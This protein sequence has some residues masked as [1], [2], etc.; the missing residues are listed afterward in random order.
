MLAKFRPNEVAEYNK[1]IPFSRVLSD[2]YPCLPYRA[3]QNQ[4]RF[5]LHIGQRKLL[6]GDIEFITQHYDK[7]KV[8]VCAGAAQGFHYKSL[9][10]LFPEFQF[11]LYDPSAFWEGLS[12]V[13]N[14][15]TYNQYFDDD[16]VKKWNLLKT[17][18]LFA[19]D[20]RTPPDNSE[21]QKTSKITSN[22]GSVSF[23]KKVTGD[24]AMQQK[25]VQDLK[26]VIA[27]LKFRLPYCDPNVRY[28][29]Q[30]TEYLD[31]EI[32]F[33]SWAPP[34]STESRLICSPL[35]DGSYKFRLYD[36]KKYEDQMFRF[37]AITRIQRFDLGPITEKWIS[38]FPG[39][40]FDYDSASEIKILTDYLKKIRKISDDELLPELFKLWT[41]INNVSGTN[42]ACSPH[43]DEPLK[44][45][46]D[47]TPPAD[48]HVMKVHRRT[49][50]RN[51]FK[52]KRRGKSR[53]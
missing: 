53:R 4:F 8:Y 38:L 45:Y 32:R 12:S 22:V 10:G 30:F 42:P 19:S 37:N 51:N 49:N 11:H 3:R 18:I 25:W 16:V 41:S 50:N 7:S 43:G 13:P 9:A 15:T 52:G 6:L 23:G 29:T 35:D 2:D 44:P 1:K 46:H 27:M 47:K 5:A 39:L 14:I 48:D 17:P 26:P 33:Q 20:I 21:L 24:M 28:G 40:E 31:G 34:S 36:D